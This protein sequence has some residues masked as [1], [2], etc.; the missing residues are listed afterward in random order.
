MGYIFRI[1]T[2][3]EMA[4]TI[5]E[6]KERSWARHGEL[7]DY[8]K[9]VYVRKDV[10]L[11]IICP[12]HGEFSQRP[13]NHWNGASCIQC[14]HDKWRIEK[15]MTKE[16]FVL[17]ANVLHKGLYDYSHLQDGALAKIIE[18]RCGE[19]GMFR[20][21]RASHLQGHGCLTCAGLHQKS[22]AEFIQAAKKVH[23]DLYG[24]ENTCYKNNRAKVLV[25]C[26]KHGDFAISPK[27]H[28]SL[29]NGCP[30]CSSSKG[31]LLIGKWLETQGIQYERQKS[32]ET[33]RN[34]RKLRF[35]F[36]LPTLNLLIEFDGIQHH[37]G[38]RFEGYNLEE[39]QLR[40]KIKNEWCQLN[41]RPLL[42]IVAGEDIEGVLRQLLERV[43][44]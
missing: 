4:L 21:Q 43:P 2:G 24:Y 18:I 11:I 35:D 3:K 10:H 33:C 42:R 12:V 28:L 27:N 8:S 5:S 40:D 23:G 39:V 37:E 6:F 9:S 19:H 20:Q 30:K 29:K 36:Y 1:V 14:V 22:S 31:E 15:R 32:F 13:D 34:K 17:R 7:Y 25:T 16:E 26:F 44:E 38:M 41:D